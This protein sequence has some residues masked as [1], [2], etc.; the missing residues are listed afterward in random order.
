MIIKPPAWRNCKERD[1]YESELE[2]RRL[3]LKKVRRD[4]KEVHNSLLIKTWYPWSFILRDGEFREFCSQKIHYDASI[5][6]DLFYKS[7]IISDK[8][9]IYLTAKDTTKKI[10]T[11]KADITHL[12][13]SQYLIPD[14]ES[15]YLK[16]RILREEGYLMKEYE[17]N[18]PVTSDFERL[19]V[20]EI[21]PNH[22]FNFVLDSVGR[23]VVKLPVIEVYSKTY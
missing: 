18:Y 1:Y 2:A 12:T 20:E 16:K 22:G 6:P 15:E 14:E 23:L 8:G 17:Y 3:F 5:F 7:R 4:I 9:R 11:L 10:Q 19:M 13:L 21:N